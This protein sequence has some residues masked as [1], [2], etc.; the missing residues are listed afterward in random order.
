MK[1]KPWCWRRSKY[2]GYAVKHILIFSTSW[3]V[4]ILVKFWNTSFHQLKVFGWN[5]SHLNEICH[6]KSW[7]A[8]SLS[9][10]G[11]IPNNTY[12]LSN[13]SI[14]S[15]KATTRP[16]FRFPAA[17]ARTIT[18]NAY[19]SITFCVDSSPSICICFCCV[20]PQRVIQDFVVVTSFQNCRKYSDF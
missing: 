14:K 10:E 9:C 19:Q 17:K 6:K 2:P 18:S 20:V 7:I 16:V 5:L 4:A 8:M 11:F 12:I 1:G 3:Y 13:L 15:V